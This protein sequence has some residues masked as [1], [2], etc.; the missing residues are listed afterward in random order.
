M[1]HPTLADPREAIPEM[2]RRI[3]ERF[4]PEKIILFGSHSRGDAGPDSDVD[5]MVLFSEVEDRRKRAGEIYALLSGILLPTDV[6][7]TTAVRMRDFQDVPNSIY[8]P[9]SR[10]GKTLYERESEDH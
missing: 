4:H 2:V 9:V 8:W 1:V 6:I 7:V 3:V 10:E 5:L